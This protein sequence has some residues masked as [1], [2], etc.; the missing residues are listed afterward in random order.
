[1]YVERN[2]EERWCNNYCKGKT[3]SIA[4]SERVFVDLVIQHAIRMR[5]IVICGLSA[6]TIFFSHHVTNSIIFVK[7]IIEHKICLLIFSTNF[8]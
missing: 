8:V 7:K 4:H 2:T 5:H 1:M 3:I 6:S